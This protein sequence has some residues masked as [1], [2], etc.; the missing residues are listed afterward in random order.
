MI[1][2]V[3][4]SAKRHDLDVWTYLRDVL[5]RLAQGEEDLDA[6]LPDRWKVTHPEAVRSYRQREREAKAAATRERRRRRRSLERA[7]ATEC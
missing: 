3:I 1:Y 7:G 2:T 6:L 5:E 4:S